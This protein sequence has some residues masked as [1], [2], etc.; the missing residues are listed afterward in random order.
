M[1]IYFYFNS[2]IFDFGPLMVHLA[3]GTLTIS[4]PTAQ[5]HS[6]TEIN[7]IKKMFTFLFIT[8]EMVQTVR[9]R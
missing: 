7:L 1:Y 8:D 9:R 6:C 4:E 3:C 5:A 2:F